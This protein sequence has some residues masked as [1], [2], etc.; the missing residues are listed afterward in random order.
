MGHRL[1]WPH[2]VIRRRAGELGRTSWPSVRV[3]FRAT[4]SALDRPERVLVY[5]NTHTRV[6]PHTCT[7]ESHEP[8]HV[9]A[10]NAEWKARTRR[11]TDGRPPHMAR[12]GMRTCLVSN[13]SD[14]RLFELLALYAASFHAFTARQVHKRHARVSDGI[15]RALIQAELGVQGL[16]WIRT[17][18]T[19]L[20]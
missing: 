14:L 12:N 7:V 10:Q 11:A 16:R 6:R 15:R 2:H 17:G 18:G 3:T 5:S 13:A 8:R 20:L 4:C 19:A 9:L 1:V